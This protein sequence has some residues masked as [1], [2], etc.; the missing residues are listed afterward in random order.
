MP[1]FQQL[2]STR[3]LLMLRFV[4]ALFSPPPLLLVL[5]FLL[6]F[7]L[8]FS[9]FF[10]VFFNCG[11]LIVYCDWSPENNV[12]VL[13]CSEAGKQ[14]PAIITTIIR[15]KKNAPQTSA[16]YPTTLPPPISLPSATM[17]SSHVHLI[18]LRG[19]HFAVRQ[20]P[21]WLSA[22]SDICTLWKSAFVFHAKCSRSRMFSHLL[23][24]HLPHFLTP[25]ASGRGTKAKECLLF[26]STRQ[27]RPS[28]SIPLISQVLATSTSA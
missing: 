21:S 15:N 6:F 4:S 8:L 17:C 5:L 1:H 25:S 11:W 23:T 24:D 18:V 2:L 28:M 26:R 9:F 3:N 27:L 19:K 12:T 20:R 16:T 22:L 10:S 7:F 14:R 13:A